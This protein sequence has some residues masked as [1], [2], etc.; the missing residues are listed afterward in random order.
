[1]DHPSPDHAF[2]LHNPTPHQAITTCCP[3]YHSHCTVPATQWKANKY[4]LNECLLA[5]PFQQVK[6]L[7]TPRLIIWLTSSHPVPNPVNASH[8]VKSQQILQAGYNRLTEG[9]DMGR[10][11]KVKNNENVQT[12][13]GSLGETE[14]TRGGGSGKWRNTQKK[15]KCWVRVRPELPR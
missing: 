11:Q 13:K 7:S 15:L 14:V 1:M 2:P 3:G 5:W 12:I 8:L 10:L 6:A 4:L 9:R